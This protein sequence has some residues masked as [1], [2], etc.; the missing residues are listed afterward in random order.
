[1]DG[2]ADVELVNRWRQQHSDLDRMIE[3]VSQ[4]IESGSSQAAGAALE[5]LG[6]ELEAHF[7]VEEEVYFPLIER[8]STL[9]VPV[10]RS[11]RLGHRKIRARMEDLRDLIE[12]AEFGPAR[13]ALAVLVDRFHTHEATEAKLVRELERAEG[14]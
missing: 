10:L 5:E 2:L 1:M 9:Y 6:D 12:R 11:A 7:A 3:D 14:L 4:A 13:R 8:V